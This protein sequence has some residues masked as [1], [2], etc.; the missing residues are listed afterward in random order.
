MKVFGFILFGERLSSAMAHPRAGWKKR[1]KNQLRCLTQKILRQP[2]C[3]CRPQRRLCSVPPQNVDNG[4]MFNI[5]D[6]V[7]HRTQ[8]WLTGT[9][10]DTGPIYEGRVVIVRPELLELVKRASHLRLV[11]PA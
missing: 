4:G 8:P 5:G 9:V 3:A 1:I 11:D 2:Q 7:R 6:R 10:W